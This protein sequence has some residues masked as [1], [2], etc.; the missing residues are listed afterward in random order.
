LGIYQGG[1]IPYSF[2]F[3]CSVRRL[4]PSIRAAWVLFPVDLQNLDEDLKESRMDLTPGRSLKEVEKQMIL[5]TLEDA[6]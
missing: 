4:I 2:N 1:L 5:K 6:G 3:N